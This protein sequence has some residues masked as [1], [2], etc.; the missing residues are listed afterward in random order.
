MDF[1]AQAF[2]E[3]IRQSLED[4]ANEA[5]AQQLGQLDARLGAL[6]RRITPTGME[7]D[8]SSLQLSSVNIH[9]QE[10]SIRL[11]GTASGTARLLLQ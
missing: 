8:M 11:D 6:M 4:A 7:L 5:L 1:L 9:I 3:P 10:G 2:R